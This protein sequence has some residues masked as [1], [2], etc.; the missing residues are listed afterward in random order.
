M[1]RDIDIGAIVKQSVLSLLGVVLILSGV[2]LAL[3][4]DAVVDALPLPLVYYTYEVSRRLHFLD[5]LEEKSDKIDVLFVGSSAVRAAFDPRTFDKVFKARTRTKM[6]SFNGGLSQMYPIGQA[7]Y[8]ERV[9]LPRVKP[10]FLFYGVRESELTS[11]KKTPTYLMHGRLEPLWFQRGA[12]PRVQAFA[13]EHLS[14]LQYRGTLYSI[15]DDLSRGLPINSRQESGKSDERGFEPG[16]KSL[17]KNKARQGHHL[18][19]YAEPGPRNRYRVSLPALERIYATCKANGVQLV[20]VHSPEHPE[21]FETEHGTEIWQSYQRDIA[22]WAAKHDAPF[23]DI[24]DGDFHSF[25][26][27]AD[28]ADYHHL[29]R[30]GAK[31]FSTLLAEH[32]AAYLKNAS[33]AATKAPGGI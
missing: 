17:A 33:V 25:G 18:W 1:N 27:D 2:E 9:W 16:E 28:Y 29:N 12:W 20:L 22:A 23:I 15:M 32:F 31:H 4:T 30:G 26:K 11:G 7:E 10:R 21:R 14:L 6:T 8:V 13:L 3:R 19:K 5:Q 24:T